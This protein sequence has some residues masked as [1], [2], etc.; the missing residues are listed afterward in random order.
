MGTKL[1]PVYKLIMNDVTAPR[2]ILRQPTKA[3][4]LPARLVNGYKD[5][6]V[7]FGF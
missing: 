4:A 1:I 7:V 3:D 2:H 5:K 6:A